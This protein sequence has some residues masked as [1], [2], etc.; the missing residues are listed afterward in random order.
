MKTKLFCCFI[1]L[2]SCTNAYAQH[3]SIKGKIIDAV[4]K[5]PIQYAT[6]ALFKANDSTLVTGNMAGSK[7]D[8]EL[9]NI[10][11]GS[12][13]L[14][15]M[16]LGYETKYLRNII[17][18]QDQ[19]LN[20]GNIGL[21]P[22]A[23]IL[24][25]VSV[26]G[27]KAS[28][29]NK[30][31][32]QSYSAS[33]FESAKG[34]SAIDVI[35]NLP[36]VSVNVEGDISVR[37][38]SGFLV[39]VNGKPVLADVQT[40]LSQIPA[41]AIENVELITA[42]SAKYDADGRGGIINIITKKN[43]TDGFVLIT[44]AQGGL[45]STTDYGNIKKPIRFG[46]DVTINYKKDKWD[47]S[48]GG[49]YTRNDNAGYR[50]GNVYTKNFTENIITRFP[51]NGERSFVKYNYAG[52]A[53]VSY[54][55]D[56]NNIFS[57]GLYIGKRYQARLADL[58][59]NNVTSDLNTNT[60]VKSTTYYNSNLQTKEGDLALGNLDYTHV[61]KNKSTLTAGLIYEHDN[62]YGGTQN[63]NLKYPIITDT[64]QYVNNPYKRPINGYRFKLDYGVNIGKGKLESGYQLRYDTQDGIV[65]YFVTPPTSQTDT[66]KFR[67]STHAKNDIN[68]L[69]S[70]YSGK[71]GKLE[72]MG[73]LRYEYAARTVNLSYDPSPHQLNLSNLFPSVNLLYTINDGWKLKA[74][75][76]KRVQRTTNLELNPI[77]EREHSETLEEGDPDLLPEFIDLAEFG[78]IRNF[79]QGSFFTTLY[80]QHIKNPIQ[81]LNSV[82]AD[83]ILNRVYTNAGTA[84]LFGLEAGTNLSPFK[85]WSIYLGGNLY[86]YKISG[87][88]HI[89][90]QPVTVLN[91]AWAYAI[92]G[93]TNLQLLK[94]LS[95]Q[96]NVN[97]LS[98][99]PTAQG[100]DSKFFVPNTSIK[101]TFMK[102]RLSASLLWQNMNMGFLGANK[103]R[104]T[105]SGPDFYTT[106]NYIS[107]TDV[108][109]INLSFNLT[110]FTGKL[111]LPNSEIG[112]KEF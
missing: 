54:T 28:A 75:Y 55:A 86:N 74:G 87:N 91:T 22:S 89:L 39:L 5:L 11:A 35:K 103:Q 98:K 79:T 14:R 13:R 17:I 104:I 26:A 44:N 52:R 72:Y 47:I 102:G 8:F 76:S 77:P 4:N 31:D 88:I 6:I 81:R 95:I 65:N 51:S 59:Y 78:T 18:T 16:F 110:R 34:G 62:L 48:V 97:Y 46:A 50:E 111:K 2:V 105:T 101:K 37:G 41:N 73:G 70:Q 112:D 93:N 58:I 100:E 64:I 96:A 23:K 32:K 9:T 49:N 90:T 94:T 61:F 107:E 82:Y 1:I 29:L 106:T 36:S 20:F 38:S 108:F 15:I 21:N 42:P 53:S 85:W 45:P 40:V 57:A 3:V 66:A 109:L 67:G 33:Q 71:A 60:P 63:R 92:N 84:R 99:R 27:K 25:E 43:A 68:S 7:G 24:N 19:D 83:T 80:Y 12:Y 56:P 69:Y 30:I 10:S